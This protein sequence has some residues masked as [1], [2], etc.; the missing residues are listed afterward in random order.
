[1]PQT[2][3][4][5]H[6][7]DSDGLPPRQ[8][9]DLPAPPSNYWRLVGPG[10]VAGGV[11]LSSG[12]FV[13][14]PYIA[15]QVGLV[16]LWGA[17]VGVIT[18]FF[19]NMEVERYTLAT[20]ETAVTGFNRFWKHWG[21]V[22]A[23]LV[24]FA[25]LWPGWALSSATLATYLF[26]GDA[27]IIAV[28][29]LLVIGAGLTLAPVIYVA[30]ER[31][32]FVKVAAVL[33]LV[34]LG[35]L[36]AIE[37]ESWRALPGGFMGIGTI[38]PSL[39]IAL[40][41][42]A[43]AFAGSGGGQNLCQSNWIRDKGFGMGQYV[44]RLVSPVTGAVEAAPTVSSYI[45]EPTPENMARWRSWWRFANVEQLLSFVLMTVVTIGLTSMMAHS[46]LFSEPNLPNNVSFLQIEAQ[47]LDARVGRWFGVLFLAI[48][49]FSLFGSAMGIIDYTSRLAA[50]ILKTTYMPNSKTS[51]SGA[52]FW[53]VWGMVGL[54]CVVLLS[55]MSQPITLLVISAS[56]GGTIMFMYSMLLIALNRKMLPPAIRIAGFR[57][58]MLVWS[59]LLFGTLAALTIYTQGQL[60]LR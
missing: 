6:L 57:V 11:G 35:V 52:Y 31:L 34:V 56:T 59:T 55:R 22:F 51:E 17:F 37:P 18:Q 9:R 20:G 5:P 47:R 60:L 21:L 38:P 45:F 49:S 44:P 50:D 30:L 33:I 27:V 41:F 25:N 12:E 28:A 2:A 19:L 40:I 1:M 4:P 58:A 29:G 36:F 23:I 8:V 43:V 24:Y 13:L 7:P 26:G 39:S 54:G 32:I 14:W 42:G 53:L 15:S 16:L 46:T 10:I 48:G 3:R